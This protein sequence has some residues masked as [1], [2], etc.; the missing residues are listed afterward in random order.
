MCH[1]LLLAAAILAW[2]VGA[3]AHA[4]LRTAD[5]AVGGTLRAA[6]PQV[7]ITFTEAVEPR[8]SAIAVTDGAGRQVDRKDVH[9]SG[10]DAHRLAVSLER[11][12][13]GEYTVTWHALS[14]DTHKTEGSYSFT[15]AP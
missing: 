9:V 15:V 7:E 5:P 14:V 4:L 2:P 8:F 6:P 13:P 11:L 1:R 12:G 3:L 10:G